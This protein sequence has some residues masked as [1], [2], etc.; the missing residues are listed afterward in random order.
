MVV[1]EVKKVERIA[2]LS[3]VP[4]FSETLTHEPVRMSSLDFSARS[5]NAKI[6]NRQPIMPITIVQC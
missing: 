3:F 4:L 2:N 6:L 5:R 1:E